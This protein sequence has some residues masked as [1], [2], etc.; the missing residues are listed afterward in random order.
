MN[1]FQE[2]EQK[3]INLLLTTS[4]KIQPIINKI[5][6]YTLCLKAINGYD[7]Y[8]I[9]HEFDAPWDYSGELVKTGK[10]L[11]VTST[12][13]LE[14]VSRMYNG[15]NTASYMSGCGFFTILFLLSG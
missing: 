4:E 11:A 5:I 7:I 12:N 15:N 6:E 14:E 8:D 2:E 3:F 9:T 10:E 1:K 13:T